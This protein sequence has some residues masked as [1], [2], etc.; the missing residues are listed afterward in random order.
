MP[1]HLLLHYLSRSTPFLG[2]LF[3]GGSV[4]HPVLKK[5][6]NIVCNPHQLNELKRQAQHNLLANQTKNTK[7]PNTVEVT[8]EDFG[9]VLIRLAEFGIPYVVLNNANKDFL[10]GGAFQGGRAQEESLFLRSTI[11]AFDAEH[12]PCNIE[13][14]GLCYT[15]EMQE[16]IESTDM[17]AA[18]AKLLA[19]ILEYPIQTRKVYFNENQVLFI[20]PEF[21]EE[22]PTGK[23]TTDSSRS[24][25]PLSPHEYTLFH[26]LRSAA[27]YV[28]AP[29]HT[30]KYKAILTSRIQAQL[31]TMIINGQKHAILGAWGCGCY[32]HDPAII[33]EIYKEEISKRR[34]EFNHIAFSIYNPLGE[35]SYTFKVFKE[36]LT[37]EPIILNANTD[38]T[39][40]LTTFCPKF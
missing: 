5:T 30:P 21:F 16:L 25:Q 36:C 35:E 20:G 11:S 37:K 3:R 32:N 15:K 18:E 38:N 28:T 33:A 22:S 29:E 24:F 1:K 12:P 4:T 39:H 34:K 17:T 31:D 7:P 26:E 2:G 10:G 9:I 27:P 14:E 13:K 6:L 19:S 40:P 8:S 23:S